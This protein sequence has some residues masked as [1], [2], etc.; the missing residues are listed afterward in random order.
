MVEGKE[1]YRQGAEVVEG[2]GGEEAGGE[3]ATGEGEV[4]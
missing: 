3:G 4:I 2:E 1:E